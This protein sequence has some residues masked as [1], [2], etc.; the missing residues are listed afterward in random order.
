M[1]SKALS[2]TESSV[3]NHERVEFNGCPQDVISGVRFMGEGL[4]EFA[5]VGEPVYHTSFLFKT[6]QL[7]GV[8]L[9][10]S[11]SQAHMRTC[12]CMHAHSLVPS[13]Y[14]SC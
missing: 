12:P 9:D 14:L 7:V 2:L 1:N 11:V 6:E 10:V 8:M 13:Q 5:P 3:Q 4:A